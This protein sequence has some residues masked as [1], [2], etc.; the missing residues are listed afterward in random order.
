M[1]CKSHV[2]VSSPLLKG[3]KEVSWELMDLGGFVCDFF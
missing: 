1:L 2:F 3:G